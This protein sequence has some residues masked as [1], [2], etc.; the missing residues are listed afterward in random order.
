MSNASELCP[1][2]KQQAVCGSAMSMTVANPA[3]KKAADLTP[4]QL[5]NNKLLEDNFDNPNFD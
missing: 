1:S 5:R 2:K 4:V 3:V